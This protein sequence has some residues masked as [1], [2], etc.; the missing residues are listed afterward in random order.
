MGPDCGVDGSGVGGRLDGGFDSKVGAAPAQISSHGRVDILVLRLRG[1]CKQRSSGH[2]L[3]GLAIPALRDVVLDPRLLQWVVAGLAESFNRCD[4]LIGDGRYRDTAGSDGRAVEVHC[5]GAAEALAAAVFGAHQFQ[6]IPQ[7]PKERRG[8]IDCDGTAL[9]VYREGNV[10][11]VDLIG[12]LAV[13]V[14]P[15]K[16]PALFYPVLTRDLVSVSHTAESHAQ[17]LPESVQ[18][19]VDFGH[20]EFVGHVVF[21]HDGIERDAIP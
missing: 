21:A 6:F 4:G 3:T 1:L 9:P 19:L 16:G 8:G 2:Q 12:R 10:G 20:R 15:G 5:A 7:D 17:H 14:C 18:V 13:A 11:H